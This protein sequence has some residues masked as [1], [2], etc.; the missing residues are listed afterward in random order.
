MSV[1]PIPSYVKD[2]KSMALKKTATVTA[3]P[4]TNNPFSVPRKEQNPNVVV[5]AVDGSEGSELA[6]QFALKNS[7]PQ[8]TLRIFCGN[9]AQLKMEDEI[10]K[11]VE[12]DKENERTKQLFKRLGEECKAQNRKCVFDTVS[13]IGGTSAL[14]DGICGYALALEADRLVV[15]ARGLSAWKRA[16]LGSVSSNLAL[17]CP[18]SVTIVK[19]S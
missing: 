8:D 2:T 12:R 11:D 3:A 15:G 18:V 10:S 1:E 19:N 5:V 13:F 7:Q 14:S 17:S 6:F 16:L 9:F 4:P